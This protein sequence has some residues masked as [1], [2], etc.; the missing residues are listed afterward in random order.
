MNLYPLQKISFL[1]VITS[2]ICLLYIPRSLGEEDD[3]QYLNCSASFQCA[4]ILNIG[5]PFWGSSRPDYCGYPEFKLNCT[6]DAPV[7][8]FQDEDY[9]VLD[10][11]QSASTLRI[12]RTDYWNNV[13]PVSPGNT[14][15]EVNRVEYASDVQELLLFYDCPPLNIPLPIQ[16]TSQFNCSINSTANY[17]NYF[18]TQNLTNSGLTNISST[19]G[20]CHTTVTARVSQSARENL[21]MNSTKDN[22]VAVL[23]SGFGLKWDASNN[24]CKQCNE[25]GGQC[26]YNTST[27]EFT[28]YCKDGPN[29]SN[30]AG[31]HAVVIFLV[32]IPCLWGFLSNTCMSY[33]EI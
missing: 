5:Y 6:G 9:R 26:G 20:T 19:F 23:D 15:I 27:A 22:L 29:P 13:C 28:C 24:L 31:M 17:I 3:E 4:N 16:L 8:S 32:L 30:C 14:T 18:V 12:A 25:T 21:A 2:T 10:I 7:I 33:I 1:L 11:N